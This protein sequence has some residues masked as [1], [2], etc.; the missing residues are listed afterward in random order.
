MKKVIQSIGIGVLMWSF[1]QCANQ[2]METPE[3]IRE[4]LAQLRVQREKL[5]KEIQELE[6]QLASM[7]TTRREVKQL[8]EVTQVQYQPFVHY[9]SLRGEVTSDQNVTLSSEMAGQIVAIWAQQGQWVNKGTPLIQLDDQLLRKSIEEVEVQLE[10]ANQLYM[11]Q[12]RLW[13]DSIGSEVQYLQ[14]KT[15]KESLEKRLASLRSQLAKTVIRAPFS[16]SVDRIYAKIGQMAVPGLPL[17]ELVG[18][19]PVQIEVKVPESYIQYVKMG[20]K[21]RFFVPDLK[22]EGIGV[23]SAVGESIDPVSRTFLIHVK[24][25]SNLPLR[26]HMSVEAYLQDY[27]NPQAIVLPSDVIGKDEQGNYYV[28]VVERKGKEGIARKRG[29]AIGYWQGDLV[30]IEKGLTLGEWV[31]TTG[32]KFLVSDQIVTIVKDYET[33][34]R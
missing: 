25:T 12:E 30:E 32:H 19:G 1:W 11:K 9:L 8:V 10:L 3:A 18:K 13:R 22:K 4:R 26:P 28:Y 24:P 17:I 34:K 27:E 7:D 20:Q 31:V 16:G 2:S 5:E 33:G 21:V 29:V 15:Q 23:V 6:K 14:A